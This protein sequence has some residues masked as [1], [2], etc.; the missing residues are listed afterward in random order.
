MKKLVL[1]ALA[2]STLAIAGC[3]Q[4]VPSSQPLKLG[5]EPQQAR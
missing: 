2:I 5:A 3:R 4:E 1:L